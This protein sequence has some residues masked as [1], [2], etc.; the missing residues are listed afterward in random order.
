MDVKMGYGP[1][2]AA[3]DELKFLLDRGFRKDSALRFIGDHHQLDTLGRNRLLRTVYSEEDVRDTKSKLR[4][5]AWLKGKKLAVDGFNVLIT[6]EAVLSGGEYFLSDDGLSRDNA[7][8]FSN[9]R[10]GH[11]T[12]KAA[13]AV[14]EVLAS[15]RPSHASWVF[16]SQIS[17]SGKLAAYVLGR[18][19]AADM[20]GDSAAYRAA[21]HQILKLGRATA[22]SDSVLVRKLRAVVDL[23]AALESTFR[24]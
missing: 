15:N 12:R 16:D 2:K 19:E 22:T 4:P 1:F 11:V 20:P 18:M 6:A 23:P 21:D 13:D 3:C 7:M 8:A 17:G 10:V 14:L 5:V 9:Y 24:G